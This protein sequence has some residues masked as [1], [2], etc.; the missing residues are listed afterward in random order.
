MKPFPEI[1]AETVSL[2]FLSFYDSDYSR[3][4]TIF[5]FP[6]KDINKTFIQVPTGLRM[7]KFLGK[8]TIKLRNTKTTYVV[9]SPCHLIAAILK[10]FTNKKIVLDAGW[11]LLDGYK[12]PRSLL[13]SK[14]NRLKIWLLDFSS[15]HLVDLVFFESQEQLIYS[16][17]KYFLRGQTLAISLTGLNESNFFKENHS[18]EST[19]EINCGKPYI[20]FRGK[21]NEEAGLE[22]IINAYRFHRINVPLVIHTNQDLDGIDDTLPIQ[23]INEYISVH[24]MSRLYRE[25]LMC[26]GQLSSHPR[27]ERTIPHKAFEAGFHGIPY[28]SMKTKAILEVFPEE[29]QVIFL[30][31]DSPEQIANVINRCLQNQEFLSKY[32]MRINLRYQDELSQAKIYSRF[33]STLRNRDMI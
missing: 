17:Q 16:K 24:E 14:F 6:D 27:L 22:N 7:V 11:P 9:M 21:M 23:V 2:V 5:N 12:S 3:S 32:S 20:L 18:F 33:I 25:A 19:F 8:M 10:F 26:L 28:I 1:D 15:F 13:K 30:E 31:N 29:N 4:A